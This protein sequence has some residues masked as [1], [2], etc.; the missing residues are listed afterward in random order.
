MGHQC[1]DVKFIPGPADCGLAPVAVAASAAAA[2]PSPPAADAAAAAA[3]T[4]GQHGKKGKKK[5]IKKDP[6]QSVNGLE[7]DRHKSPF[8]YIFY[9]S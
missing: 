9:P 3:A 4:M 6:E 5:K 2:P 8:L 7:C 1:W